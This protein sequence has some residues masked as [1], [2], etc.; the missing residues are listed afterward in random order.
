MTVTARPDTP[1]VHAWAKLDRATHHVDAL[2]AAATAFLEDKPIGLRAH[3]VPYAKTFWKRGAGINVES[4]IE[5]PPLEWATIIG[6]ALQNLRSSLDHLIYELIRIDHGKAWNGSQFPI[7]DDA[8]NLVSTPRFRDT[9][10]LLSPEHAR[11]VMESQ[12][13]TAP[14]WPTFITKGER[15]RNFHALSLLRELSNADK[16]RLLNLAFLAPA[17]LIT[18]NPVIQDVRILSKVDFPR[19]PLKKGDIVSAIEWVVTGPNPKVEFEPE[20][21]AQICLDDGLPIEAALHKIEAF[22]TKLIRSF[23]KALESSRS[24]V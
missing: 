5:E 7:V 16:H 12:P 4:D 18:R 22:I 14:E 3:P 17:E 6:D 9:L 15:P 24:G 1:F 20:F 19:G 2:N 21:V 13:Y 11:M 10:A 23:E 8:D